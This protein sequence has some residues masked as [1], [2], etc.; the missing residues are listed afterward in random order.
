MYSPTITARRLDA[1][2]RQGVPFSRLSREKSI[3]WSKELEQLRFSPRGEPLPHGSLARPLRAEEHSFI[4]SERLICK[5]DFRYFLS[6]Y[7]PVERDP[8][9]S[10]SGESGIGP[11]QLLESQVRFIQALGKREEI[12][13][14]EWTKHRHT[15]GILVYAHKCRQVAF[16]ATARALTLHRLLFWPGT[17]AFAGTLEPDGCGELYKRDKIAL[18]NL[19][20][21]L[22]PSPDDIYPDVKD[23]EIGLRSPFSSRLRFQP[24]NQKTGIGVGTQ[25]DISHLTEVPLWRYPGQINFSF[26]PAL[27]KARTT[28]HIQEGTSAGRGGHWQEASEGCRQRRRGYEDWTYI[29]VP[30]Y[31]NSR[32]WR[33]IAPSSW[34]PEQHTL[35]HAD[36][37][38]RTSP[39]WN[40]GIT[41]RPGADQLYWWETERARHQR[42]GELAAFLANFPA[43]P[44]QSFVNWNQGALPMELIEAMELDVRPPRAYE[45]STAA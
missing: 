17:R 25:I 15:A 34:S 23:Q 40:S 35:A 39:E 42:N 8:G 28:L 37:I 27:P 30:W 31:L 20:F 10:D 43:T 7:Y 11:A 18:E 9:V 26:V 45:V 6:R 14:E 38:E 24:E 13:F 44:E 5:A 19:P 29:F 1:A 16:T 4:E 3:T 33:A 36:L 41:V 2:K 22:K 21:W 32:K 12:T